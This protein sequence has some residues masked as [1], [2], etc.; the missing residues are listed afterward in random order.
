MNV[1]YGLGWMLSE[2]DRCVRPGSNAFWHGGAYGSLG[3]A[4]PDAAL[5]I[6]YV[7]NQCGEPQLDGRAQR[8]VDAVYDCL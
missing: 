5:G 8:L 7:F 6:G 2:G 3:H 1:A 4:D